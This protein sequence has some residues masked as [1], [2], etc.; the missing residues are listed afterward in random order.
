MGYKQGYTSS[1]VLELE[2][3][4]YRD[5]LLRQTSETKLKHNKLHNSRRS[6]SI[7]ITVGVSIGTAV[8][9]TIGMAVCAAVCDWFFTLHRFLVGLDVKLDEKHQIATEHTAT[10][11]SSSF[12]S[13]A[14]A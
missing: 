4:F 6:I 11:E 8:S 9:N 7:S 1:V 2:L 5:C 14:V 10:E 13:S 3:I 12:G